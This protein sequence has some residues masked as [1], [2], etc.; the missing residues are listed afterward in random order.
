M[1]DLGN[2]LLTHLTNFPLAEMRNMSALF[3]DFVVSKSTKSL[4]KK[5]VNIKSASMPTIAFS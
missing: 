4:G 1:D 2:E 5:K 3:Q